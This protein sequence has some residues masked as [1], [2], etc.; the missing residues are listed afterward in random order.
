MRRLLNHCTPHARPLKFT[1]M[2]IKLLFYS[3]T[4]Q[5]MTTTQQQSFVPPTNDKGEYVRKESEYRNWINVSP[6]YPAE[7]GRYHLYISHA[8]PWAHR[9]MILR[10]LKGLEDAITYDVVDYF[11]ED[12]WVFEHPDRPTDT[13][14]TV[15]GTKNLLDVY[16]KSNPDHFGYSTVPVLFD[17]KTLTIVNNE[18]SEIIQMLNSAFNAFAKNPTLDLYPESLK[19]TVDEVNAWVYPLINNGVYRSGFATSQSAY[20]AAVTDVFT[21]LDKAEAI[22]AKS[23]YLTGSHFTLADVRLFTTLLRFDP[24]YVL[25]FKTNLRRLIDYPNLFAYTREIYQM[26]GVAKTVD[27]DNIKKHY[28]ISHRNINPHGIVPKGP[29]ID[30]TQPHGREKL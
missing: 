20:E 8:C 19:A 27:M 25:H 30:Y 21:G 22:L 14:D 7:S 16:K 2:T 4:K 6:N 9:C 3:S 10:S 13:K 18:S 26:E 15:L 11:L 28:F 17:K 29:L 12:D 5:H 1:T 23:R 24:V